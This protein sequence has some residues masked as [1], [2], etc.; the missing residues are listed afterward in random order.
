MISEKKSLQDSTKAVYDKYKHL[1]P[2]E[3]DFVPFAGHVVELSMPEDYNASWKKWDLQTLPIIPQQFIYKATQDKIRYYKEAADKIKSGKYDYIC[4]N[5]DPGREGQ[6]IFHAFI[7][8]LK[9]KI[10]PIKRLWALDTTEDSVKDALLNMRDETEPA[11]QGMTDASFLRSYMDW[12]VGMNFSRAV[13][14]KSYQK[15]N[16]GRVM[17]PTL[18]IVVDRELE[19]RN[20]TPRD[21]WQLEADFG[22][23]KG[24]YIDEEGV[25]TFY[26]QQKAQNKM[27]EVGTQG[28]ITSVEKKTSK[29]YAPR[30]HSLADLQSEANELFGYTMNET[31]AIV[32]SLYEKKLLSY[33]RTDSS[34]IT[35]AI[36]KGFSKMLQPLLSIPSITAEAQA[37]LNN[38][39][40][41]E[42]VAKNK[43]YVDD[44]KVSDHFAITPTGAVPD[45]SKLT[46]DEKNIYETVAKRF[47]A[48]FLPPEV[49][50]RTTIL[51]DSNGLTFRTTGKIVKDP[52]YTRIY[53]KQSKDVILPNV[54]K[55][56]VFDVVDV[57]LNQ[58]K[59]KPPAR[60]NDK[61][62]GNIME[63]VAR[64]VEDDE[65]KLVLKE[66]KGLGTP[67]TRGSIVEKL[68]NLKMIERKKKN[69][70]AT[71]YG[72]SII[73][74]LQG[75]DI[76]QPELT[77]VWESKLGD[78]EKGNC[79][80]AQFY[81]EMIQY[82]QEKTGELIQ[83]TTHIVGGQSRGNG[84][85]SNRKEIGPCPVCKGTVIE[86]K[87]YYLCEHYKNPCTF[88]LGKTFFNAK[89]SATE[90]KKLLNGKETKE[91]SMS[92]NQKTW[93]AKLIYDKTQQKVIFSSGQSARS[94]GSK[95]SEAT[96]LP[97]C[98][99]CGGTLKESE[100]YYIC[101][102]YKTKCETC[103]PKVVS[104]VKLTKTEVKKLL[105]GEIIGPKT[106]TWKNGKQGQAKLKM[107][108]KL[109][110]V[111]DN[112]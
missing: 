84:N 41:Q 29:S 96:G 11:L 28:V 99:S 112:N 17:T 109:E 63:N 108:H 75:Q 14:I 76:I 107:T 13:S 4:N 62:L 67:A 44:K 66:K 72:I 27:K 68:V 15:V 36:A 43:M 7:S 37:V 73:Q 51:T 46:Q 50:D 61:T 90:V 87:N 88:I 21:F 12:L 10:P 101:E 77:A 102:G 82:I 19:I 31:L 79:T 93:K 22:S 91:L 95:L 97:K 6:L 30:L 8:T 81:Q 33:P 100:K 34:Y 103:I 106:F 48:I 55:G 3:I 60:Y 83:M 35:T 92:N 70:Y 74:S 9:C 49:T 45:F 57:R 5:C 86:G 98:S 64:L 110:Y 78:V 38:T 20:F 89:I 94:G 59:T 80:K 16:L 25:V 58:G 53:N 42:Q 18:K 39:H 104:G 56:E 65:M 105:K 54:K 71:D 32:Q 40:L 52:G 85:L 47:L 24:T 69:F 111:F 26:D 2:Y 23:Y 1:I